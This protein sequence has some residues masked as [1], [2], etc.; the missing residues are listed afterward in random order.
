M[1]STMT[2]CIQLNFETLHNVAKK[3]FR[4]GSYYHV[5]RK[6]M[7][8]GEATSKPNHQGIIFGLWDIRSHRIRYWLRCDR[9]VQH[10]IFWLFNKL[11]DAL[12]WES[13]CR[14]VHS[15]ILRSSYTPSISLTYWI[16]ILE[17]LAMFYTY[18]LVTQNCQ[19]YCRV[20][21]RLFC[22]QSKLDWDPPSLTFVRFATAILSAGSSELWVCRAICDCTRSIT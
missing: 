2:D 17:R 5:E 11:E 8:V 20:L 7:G 6:M 1:Y 18:E 13:K 21:S 12:I 14:V 19:A 16:K 9:Y 22:M 15:K 4:L 3:G 10:D